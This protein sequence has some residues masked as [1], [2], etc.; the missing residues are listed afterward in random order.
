MQ[1]PLSNRIILAAADLP[2]LMPEE[3]FFA[4]DTTV[5]PYIKRQFQAALTS[6]EL[7]L[8]NNCVGL[9]GSDRG[10]MR[11]QLFGRQNTKWRL[12]TSN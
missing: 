11:A 6:G 4:R 8:I 2:R 12:T 9:K 1:P 10:Q 3:I 5:E 7:V